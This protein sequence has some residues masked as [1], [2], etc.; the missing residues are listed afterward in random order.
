MLLKSSPPSKTPPQ[1]AVMPPVLNSTNYDYDY[2]VVQPYFFL[3]GEEED[4][5]PPP[6]SQLLPAPSEDIWKKF[7]LLPTPPLSPS[8][9]PSLSAADHLEAVSD[10]LD[11][12]H[13][14]SAAFLQSF[15]IQD[16]MWS[17]S[18]AAA[19]ELE[20]VVSERLASLRARRDSCNTKTITDRTADEQVGGSQVSAGYLQDFHT[21]VTDCIDPS[22]V[23]LGEKQMDDGVA[24][25]VGSELR[26]DSPP[27]SSS[28]SESEEEDD[29]E[30]EEEIDVV[31]VDRRKSSRR[32]HTSPLV[33]KRS[34][35][36]IHQHNY[37]AQQPPEKRVK[38]ESSSAAPRQSG[39]RRCWS[40]KSEGED[41][42]K[43]RTHNVLERQRRNELKMSF[44]V[45]RDE[46]PAVANNEKA[47]KVVILKKAAEFIM[48]VREQERKLLAKKDEL[49]K[50]SRELKQRLQQLRTSH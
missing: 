19:T 18:F 45:L 48:E 34:H 41:N 10:L 16:C 29:D 47:A 4:F 49:R 2:D 32:S 33:L 30:E 25:E 39:G 6:R 42:D 38:A 12:D 44:M 50:R 15:I 23:F 35:V 21:S 31:T 26:L 37:A 43:R 17:S 7:E 28:D 11:D 22:V 1:A 36:N 27:P 20:K 9:R 8:R 24:M 5:Y 3:N 13:S 46:V 14:S 40:P